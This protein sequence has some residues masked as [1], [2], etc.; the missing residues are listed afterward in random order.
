[1]LAVSKGRTPNQERQRLDINGLFDGIMKVISQFADEV[2]VERAHDKMPVTGRGPENEGEKTEN[3]QAG[4]KRSEAEFL[5]R[6]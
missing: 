4:G 6:E 3:F 1:L 5:K 2:A